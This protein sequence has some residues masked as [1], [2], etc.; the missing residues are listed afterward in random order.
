M[1]LDGPSCSGKGTLSK[2]IAG[3]LQ[4]LHI[5]SGLFYRSVAYCFIVKNFSEITEKHISLIAQS[6]YWKLNERKVECFLD[7]T[8]LTEQVLRS[9]QT[10][11][12]SSILAQ[13]PNIRSFIQPIIRE[14]ASQAKH[15]V[16]D[17]R[18]M[19]SVVFPQAQW[20]FFLTAHLT[21]RAQ[22]RWQQLREQGIVQSLEEVKTQLQERDVRDTTRSFDPL[23]MSDES[24]LIDT[25]HLT[26]T[27]AMEKMLSHL[28][29]WALVPAH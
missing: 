28:P 15:C 27:Q 7:G 14:L 4:W 22:R 12:W 25:S 6:L 21:I 23:T 26:E 18:D 19:A 16:A 3:R 2:M 17:G 29:A 9:A 5:D 20:K 8:L 1:T 10:S 24:I 11:K 13:Q